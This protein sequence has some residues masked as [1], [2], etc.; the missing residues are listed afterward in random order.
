[1]LGSSLS[2]KEDED[3][4]KG[5]RGR[6][7]LLVRGGRRKEVEKKA[8]EEWRRKI[9]VSEAL[10][11]VPRKGRVADA[12]RGRR[13]SMVVKRRRRSEEDR[14]EGRQLVDGRMHQGG[15]T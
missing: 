1:M 5:A 11:R 3:R 15:L 13:T 7:L 12:R 2:E 8:E 10:R 4:D 9:A 14:G 6:G